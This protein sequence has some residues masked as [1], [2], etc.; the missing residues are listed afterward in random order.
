MRRFVFVF[1]STSALHTLLFISQAMGQPKPPPPDVVLEGTVRDLAAQRS[2]SGLTMRL[3][4]PNSVGS[5]VRIVRTD[6]R[7]NFRFSDPNNRYHGKHLLEVYQGADLLFRK[8]IDT[9]LPRDR[10]I[11]VRVRE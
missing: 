3:T 9:Q 11:L 7:G 4:P 8:E 2:L 10:R 1:F 6:E 5:P